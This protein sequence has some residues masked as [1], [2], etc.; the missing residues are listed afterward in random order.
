MAR[1]TAV[2]VTLETVE[3][4][5]TFGTPSR[6]SVGS[7]MVFR[8]T[9]GILEGRYA[10][11]FAEG[12][13][14][15][16]WDCGGTG[17]RPGYEFSDSGRCWPCDYSGLR[18]KIGGGTLEELAKVLTRRVKDK[19]RRDAARKAKLEAEAAAAQA[20]LGAWSATHPELAAAALKY[21][22]L[23]FCSHT[24]PG[25]VPCREDRCIGEAYYAIR[26]THSDTLFALAWTAT[27]RALDARETAD[28]AFEVERQAKRDAAREAQAAKAAAKQ[29][30]GAEGQKITVTGA[31]AKPIH[32]ESE[33]GTST[34]YKVTTADGDVVTWFRSGW[35]DWE[36]G[37]VVTLTGTVKALTETEKYG[38]ET[39][40]TRCKVS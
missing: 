3:A 9:T 34:L 2:T 24:E 32:I 40:L 7:L 17:Y 27:W 26:E 22:A 39:Q 6:R 4:H 14:E 11:R 38:K 20:A 25:G 37:E 10:A 21:V 5:T 30:L 16:C 12:L 29:W 19:A 28:F 23:G 31:L 8:D 33:W 1:K 15:I 18:K 35:F 13:F 36:A